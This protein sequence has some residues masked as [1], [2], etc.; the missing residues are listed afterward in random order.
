MWGVSFLYNG[1][2][3]CTVFCRALLKPQAIDL[4]IAR[5]HVNSK[6]NKKKSRKQHSKGNFCSTDSLQDNL[7]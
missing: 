1:K 6:V 4:T 3:I 5:V 2:M 7:V